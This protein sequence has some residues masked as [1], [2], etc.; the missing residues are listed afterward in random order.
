MKKI[1]QQAKVNRSHIYVITEEP[2]PLSPRANRAMPTGSCDTACT[3]SRCRTVLPG[4]SL[5]INPCVALL[6]LLFLL[7]Y[8]FAFNELFDMNVKYQSGIIFCPCFIFLFLPAVIKLKKMNSFTSRLFSLFVIIDKK[9][10][11]YS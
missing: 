9:T 1:S 2:T 10:A 4:K 7:V 11:V 8:F 5:S 6:S 3:F